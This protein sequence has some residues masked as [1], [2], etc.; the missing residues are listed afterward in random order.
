M[1]SAAL[2]CGPW[3]LSN[4]NLTQ[5]SG[6]TIH[7]DAPISY[8]F[9]LSLDTSNHIL[10]LA[11]RLCFHLCSSCSG[12]LFKNS[13]SCRFLAKGTKSHASVRHDLN[14]VPPMAPWPANPST[15]V[16]RPASVIS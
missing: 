8:A 5:W 11:T 12:P 10:E 16:L 1:R 4:G 9:Y 6:P 3:A 2:I 14:P 15:Q 7:K 13:S